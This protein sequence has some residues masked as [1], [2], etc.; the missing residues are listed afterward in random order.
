MTQLEHDS[1]SSPRELHTSFLA[2]VRRVTPHH[3]EAILK[4]FDDLVQQRVASLVN[5][6]VV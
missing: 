4:H 1:E 2:L 6:L 3:E 5:H